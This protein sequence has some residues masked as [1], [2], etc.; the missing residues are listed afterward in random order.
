MIHPRIN[1]S[2][3]ADNLLALCARLESRGFESSMLNLRLDYNEEAQVLSQYLSH[4]FDPTAENQPERVHP[5]FLPTQ[6]NGRWSIK[7][8][9]LINFPP[10]IRDV[11]VPDKD[12]PW[13]CWDWD[14]L[15]ALFCAAYT[16]DK[17]DLEAFRNRWDLHTIAAC[18]M[19]KI[20][21]PPDLSDPHQSPTCAEWREQYNWKGKDDKRRVMAKVRYALIFGKDWQ[22]V[23]GSKYERDFIKGG[24][25]KV[26]EFWNAAKLFLASKPGLISARLKW[27]DRLAKAGV[28]TTIM[29]RKRRLFGDYW[30]RA[31]EGWNHLFQGLEPDLL[32]T[33]L[34]DLC[35]AGRWSL[36]YPSHD[37]A[38]IRV[39]AI[40]LE[41]LRATTLASFKRAVEHKLIIEGEEITCY[42]TWQIL[43]PDGSKEH[44]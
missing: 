30:I 4:V 11:L 17:E 19:L 18:R 38:K 5:H 40:D 14:S 21:L 26:E 22:A 31:K 29:G 7:N 6:A 42:A 16:H 3:N 41:E 27:F 15:Y 24:H 28:A 35:S 39:P 36:V 1:S 12:F 2:V 20:P 34:I 44:M 32:N 33:S 43:H 13:V 10:D 8:P 23:K 9:P 37:G 25:G